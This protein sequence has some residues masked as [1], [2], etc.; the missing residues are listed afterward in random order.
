[1]NAAGRDGSLSGKALKFETAAREL[2]FL[3]VRGRPCDFGLCLVVFPTE[4]TCFDH[5]S[6][7]YSHSL[8]LK[9]WFVLIAIKDSGHFCPESPMCLYVY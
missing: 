2:F 7:D 3:C 6:V 8:N 4:N 9:V 1:M 5:L